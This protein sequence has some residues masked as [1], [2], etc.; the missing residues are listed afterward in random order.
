MIS[1][2]VCPIAQIKSLGNAIAR[3]MILEIFFETSIS[4]S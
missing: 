3:K 4:D 1:F 2:G